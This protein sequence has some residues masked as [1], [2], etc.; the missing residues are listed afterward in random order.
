MLSALTGVTG[1]PN[2]DSDI[3]KS[4]IKI[5]LRFSRGEK[6]LT[7]LVIFKFSMEDAGMKQFYLFDCDYTIT[8]LPESCLLLQMKS[9][10][11]LNYN[12]DIRNISLFSA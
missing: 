6:K 9:S 7:I 2:K 5:I 3:G 1:S 11:Q 8:K 4:Y 10:S 12:K